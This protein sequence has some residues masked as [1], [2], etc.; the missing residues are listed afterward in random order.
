M[1]IIVGLLQGGWFLAVKIIAYDMNE[2]IICKS[3]RRDFNVGANYADECLVK[4]Y[5]DEKVNEFFSK[6]DVNNKGFVNVD[7]WSNG[8]ER[9]GIY[10]LE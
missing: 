4:K 7:E 8:L 10:I 9:V 5:D 3:D 1:N 6:I 2:N